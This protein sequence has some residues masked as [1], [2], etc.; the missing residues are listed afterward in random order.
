M[1][2]RWECE[3]HIYDGKAISGNQV[4]RP[5]TARLSSVFTLLLESSEATS[6]QGLGRID[7]SLVC[8][9]TEIATAA[10]VA[11]SGELPY[12]VVQGEQFAYVD[13]RVLRVTR[14]GESDPLSNTYDVGTIDLELDGGS[15]VPNFWPGKIVSLTDLELADLVP[16]E[17]WDHS[18]ASRATSNSRLGQPS[19]AVVSSTLALSCT[20][21]GAPLAVRN[22]ASAIS[23]S[24][25][26]CDTL[27]D[28]TEC[29][30]N[31]EG[32]LKA[33]LLQ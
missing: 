18:A 11:A 24:C 20:N 22:P 30:D 12:P 5:E 16:F 10:I 3:F 29:S 26:Y 23:I 17:G 2:I 4:P 33:H 6:Y 31:H 32:Q 14:A 28:L 13:V 19:G 25:E 15:S 1:V 21:C 9:P 27:F 8:S 7:L